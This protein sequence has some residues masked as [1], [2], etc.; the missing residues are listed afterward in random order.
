[1]IPLDHAHF[2]GGR[3]KALLYQEGGRAVL[4]IL[5]FQQIS[6]AQRLDAFPSLPD[7]RQGLQGPAPRLFSLRCSFSLALYTGKVEKK[8]RK[9]TKK[10]KDLTRGGLEPGPFEHTD[11]RVTT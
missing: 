3:E 5:Y 10:A 2:D 6:I 8:K 1:M 11:A 7:G 9:E 4:Y